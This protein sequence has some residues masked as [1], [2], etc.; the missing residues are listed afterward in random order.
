MANHYPR[1][2]EH[3]EN[4]HVKFRVALS[5]A[6][7]MFR[8]HTEVV[9]EVMR[10]LETYVGAVGP[11]ALKYYADYEDEALA[12]DEAVRERVRREM[13]ER[14]GAAEVL[15]DAGAECY[16]RFMYQ[17]RS[18]GQSPTTLRKGE[19]CEARF[20]LPTEFL[21][22]QGPARVRELALAMA[23]P[24]PFSSGHAGLSFNGDP[25]MG[26]KDAIR[27]VCFRFPGI[28]I[29]G[30]LVSRHRLGTHIYGVHWLTFLGQPALGALGGVEG[31]RAQLHST[32]TSVQEMEGQRAV[33]TLGEWPEAGDTERGDT[34]P[35]YRELAR[36]LEPWFYYEEDYGDSAF[37][38]PEK[39]R[40]ERRFLD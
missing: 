31:L 18:L 13:L 3:W 30:E 33:I 5:F 34:L 29:S 14:P 12:L 20:W 40:W 2:C 38:A 17:G 39:R 10:A 28:D 15:F 25:R 19:V 24:L 4:G 16:H 27:E 1:I 22:A 21:E 37:P 23:A 32:G 11:H 6:F 36:V 8:P 35:A 7:Y 26:T 9:R